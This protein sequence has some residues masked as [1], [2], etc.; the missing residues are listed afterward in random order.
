MYRASSSKASNPSIERTA[1]GQRI[2]A[3]AHVKRSTDRTAARIVVL[4]PVGFGE[5]CEA[6]VGK[7]LLLRRS[8]D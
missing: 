3:A 4:R 8:R 2:S 6:R 5:S 7:M 1:K